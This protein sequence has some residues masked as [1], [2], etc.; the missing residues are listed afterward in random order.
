MPIFYDNLYERVSEQPKSSDIFSDAVE[1]IDR[2]P[3]NGVAIFESDV[4]L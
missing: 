3:A 2:W 1:V 4:H